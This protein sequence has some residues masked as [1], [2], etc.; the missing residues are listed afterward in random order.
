MA[1]PGRSG[2]GAV[3]KLFDY[4]LG[5]LRGCNPLATRFYE[6]GTEIKGSV[7]TSKQL[8]KRRLDDKEPGAF[9]RIS[10]TWVYVRVQLLLV[11]FLGW[12]VI[13]GLVHDV[14]TVSA[15]S[16]CSITLSS[17][18]AYCLTGSFLLL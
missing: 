1:Q 10:R 9:V 7:E 13:H 2:C 18:P 16:T 17:P 14:T 5:E 4:G 6:D 12:H 11:I 3:P 8:I 15:S